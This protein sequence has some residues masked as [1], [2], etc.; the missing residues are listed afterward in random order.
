M[1]FA[2][3]SGVEVL[4]HDMCILD[5]CTKNDN[6]G[7]GGSGRGDEDSRCPFFVLVVLQ[8]RVYKAFPSLS[9]TLSLFTLR[10]VR[11][12]EKKGLLLLLKLKTTG[13]DGVCVV[14]WG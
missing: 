9:L 5:I 13:I 6:D 2:W 12:R 1:V 14:F 10:S 4:I 7:G 8:R 3:S 11:A